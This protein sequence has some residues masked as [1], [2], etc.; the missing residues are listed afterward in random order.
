MPAREGHDCQEFRGREI[1]GPARIRAGADMGISTG[2]PAAVEAALDKHRAQVLT[3]VPRPV[4]R[5]PKRLD[6]LTFLAAW[7]PG[8][9]QGF[10]EADL[11]SRPCDP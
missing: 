1:L 2:A 5:R 9:K 3:G 8:Q 10:C 4:A 7:L 11:C 6:R